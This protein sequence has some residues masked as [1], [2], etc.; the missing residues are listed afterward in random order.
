MHT[1]NARPSDL[2]QQTVADRTDSLLKRTR[3]KQLRI[4]VSSEFY[5]MLSD[6]DL[7]AGLP[8]AGHVGWQILSERLKHPSEDVQR[9]LTVALETTLA[10]DMTQRGIPDNICSQVRSALCSVLSEQDWETIASAAETAIQTN[11]RQK[12]AEAKKT[13]AASVGSR[14]KQSTL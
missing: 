6:C 5:Q 4:L 14:I 12:I 8:E 9:Q 1:Q 11:V 3:R 7:G 10:L 2:D 13:V